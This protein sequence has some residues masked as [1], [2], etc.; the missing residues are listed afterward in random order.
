MQWGTVGTYV[1][2]LTLFES[3]L[4]RWGGKGANGS[5]AFLILQDDTQLR[6]KNSW[7]K[8]LRKDLR[9]HATAGTAWERLLLVWWG[10]ERTTDCR[11]HGGW[12]LVRPPAGPT[13][14]GDG[15]SAR[16]CVC[17]R[18]QGGGVRQRRSHRR[19]R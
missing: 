14:E 8:R 11:S 17:G 1:S 5:A 12:C 15:S 19:C 6:P 4:E 13:E 18:A 7:L 9:A 2:H 16:G 10:E 3:I